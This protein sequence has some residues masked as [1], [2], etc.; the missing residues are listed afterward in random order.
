LKKALDPDTLLALYMNGEVLPARHGFPARLIAPGWYGM[1]SV[2]WLVSL[3]VIAG[4]FDGFYAASRYREMRGPDGFDVGRLVREILVKALIA[5]PEP[6]DRIRAGTPYIVTGAAWSGVAPVARVLV[7]VNGGRGW[8]PATLAP[9]R[10][11]HAWQQWEYTWVPQ[12][13]GAATL[14]ARAFDAEG[15]AQ[16]IDPV[17]ERVY[18][19]NWVQPVTVQ[20]ERGGPPRA[21]RRR[22]QRDARPPGPTATPAPE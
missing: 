15:R 3:R 11:R 2:K 18:E 7:S 1:D 16:P 5:R 20:V 19:A 6:A 21:A 14:I 22:A 12:D 9:Q 4:P 10:S 8:A 13:A 17:P